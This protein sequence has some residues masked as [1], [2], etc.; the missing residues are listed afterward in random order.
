MRTVIAAIFVAGCTAGNQPAS[1]PSANSAAPQAIVPV[2][3]AKHIVFLCNGSGSMAGPP[4]EV[5][6]PI[7]QRLVLGLGYETSFNVIFFQHVYDHKEESWFCALDDHLLS[8]TD[9]NQAK[10]ISF[11]QRH[12]VNDITIPLDAI[13]EAFRERPD[14]ILLVTNSNFAEPNDEIVRERVAG[15]NRRHKVRLDILVLLDEMQEKKEQSI[16]EPLREIARE[17]DGACT[18]LYVYERR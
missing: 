4:E 14:Q 17:N 3:Q 5:W 15:L 10:A 12:A 16:L 11:I 2:S 13:D 1:Q 6:R 7:L 8:A 18:P 9:H